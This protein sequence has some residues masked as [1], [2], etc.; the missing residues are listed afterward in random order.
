MPDLI[1]CDIMMPKID[2]LEVTR[3]LKSNFTTSHI[4]VIILTAKST[5]EQKIDGIETGADDYITKPFNMR[6]LLKR[7]NNII[8]Q[9]KKLKEKFSQDPGIK[10]EKL[11]SSSADQ[12]FLANVISLVENNMRN[13]D[14]SIDD[15]VVELGHSRTVFYKKMKGITGYAPKEFTRLIRMKKAAVLLRETDI[16]ATQVSYEIGYNDPDYFSKSFKNFFGEPPSEYQKKFKKYT[17]N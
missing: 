16:T 8:N 15:M 7:I 14:F 9:R 2:G 3:Q 12:K 5:T 10:P 6:Y 11:S 17:V 13:P 4:P 1:I